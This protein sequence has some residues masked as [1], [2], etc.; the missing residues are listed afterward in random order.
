MQFSKVHDV[1]GM[2]KIV[3]RQ[4]REDANSLPLNAVA[5]SNDDVSTL[6]SCLF[7]FTKTQRTALLQLCKGGPHGIAGK[8][9]KY[10]VSWEK[11]QCLVDKMWINDEVINFVA[12][13]VS[14]EIHTVGVW[15]TL[16]TFYWSLA[17]HGKPPNYSFANA[18][19]LTNKENINITILKTVIIP[20]HVVPNH[21]VVIVINLEQESIHYFDSLHAPE[22]TI[23]VALGD[24]YVPQTNAN[25]P[26]CRYGPALRNC[27]R[28][29]VD[30][31]QSKDSSYVKDVQDWKGIVHSR[32]EV[33]QQDNG[34][35]CGVFCM[36]MVK[37]FAKSK[38]PCF[39]MGGVIDVPD[40]LLM[41]RQIALS[42]IKTSPL[43]DADAAA[44]AS[45]PSSSDSAL[46]LTQLIA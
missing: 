19:K 29:V 33:P 15:V 37:T 40:I 27:A 42:I 30:E 7:P 45:A 39:Q 20:L 21:W 18:K 2:D 13:S 5:F 31:F 44:P 23:T 3:P 9:D 6:A 38:G 10:S 46:L 11:L 43:P 41:R 34:Y 36:H 16:S 1:D 12:R 35:D 26:L 14:L 24:V 17:E 32:H 8:V 4:E 22:D 25:G 28:W